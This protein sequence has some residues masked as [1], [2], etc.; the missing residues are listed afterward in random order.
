VEGISSNGKGVHGHSTLD[1]G[2]GIGVFGTADGSGPAIRGFKDS[3]G[4][5]VQ[6]EILMSSSGWT[7]VHGVTNGSGVGVVGENKANGPGA[8]GVAA[9]T[10]DG[11]YG[12]SALGRGGHFTGKKAQ[13]KLDPST[14]ATHPSSG[15]AG[16]IFLDKSKRLWL[17]KGGTSW[18][19]IV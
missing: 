9:G 4:V 13:L 10:G 12:Q 14:A 1:S 6:G 18:V 2:T 7:A 8:W 16:D 17:C 15:A 3:T 11:V 19:R 5:A